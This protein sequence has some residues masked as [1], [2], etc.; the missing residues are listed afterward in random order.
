MAASLIKSISLISLYRKGFSVRHQGCPPAIIVIPVQTPMRSVFI[1]AYF[2]DKV[3]CFK[4][5]SIICHRVKYSRNRSFY[6]MCRS[7]IAPEASLPVLINNIILI[8]KFFDW[9]FNKKTITIFLLLLSRTCFAQYIFTTLQK[10]DGLSSNA[11]YCSYKDSTGFMWFGTQFG[12]NR[13]DGS[14]FKI[15]NR[16]NGK[17]PALA[18]GIVTSVTELGR[19]RIWVGTTKGLFYS[20]KQTGSFKQVP[21]VKKNNT[22]IPEIAVEKLVKDNSNRL[23]IVTRHG[24]FV[25]R[26]GKAMAASAIYNEAAGLDNVYIGGHATQYDPIRNGLWLGILKGL[27]FLDL[28]NGHL[29]NYKN[30][31]ERRQL[32]DSLSVESIAMDKAGDIWISNTKHLLACYHFTTNRFEDVEYINEDTKWK[33]ANGCT[34]LFVDSKNRLWISSWLGKVFVKEPGKKQF[35]VLP[36]ASPIPFNLPLGVFFDIYEDDQQNLWIG[37]AAGVS[38]LEPA[39]FLE[40][41]I[42]LP[43]NIFN[44][45]SSF[46]ELNAIQEAG[47]DSLWAC[48][49]D[50]LYVVDV[51]TGRNKQYIVSASEKKWNR[52]FDVQKISGECWCGTGDGIKILNPRTGQFRPFTFYAKGHE[53]KNRSVTWIHQDRKGMIWFAAWA[54]GV[55]IHD[56]LSRQTKRV[57]D[58]PEKLSGESATVNSLCILEDKEGKIWLSNGEKG[59]RIFNYKDSSFSKPGSSNAKSTVPDELIVTAIC[60]DGQLNKWLA[61][62]TR[63]ILK[64]DNNGNLTDS[65]TAANGLI[66]PYISVLLIDESGR[67]W[68]VNSEGLFYINTATKA[69]V[70]LHADMGPPLH[71]LMGA[72]FSTGNKLYGSMANK[73]A[74]IDILKVEKSVLS[75]SPLISGISVFEKEI[76]FSPNKPALDLRYN[77]NFFSI[78]FSSPNHRNLSS[79]QYAYM[80]K[81]FDKGWVYCNR[82]Q[83]ASYTNVP[84]GRY[85]FLVKC[86]DENGKWMEKETI[87]DIYIK[88]PFWKT[89]W[90]IG[91]VLLLVSAAGWY[92]YKRRLRQQQKKYIDNT[93]DYFANSVYGQNSVDEI[94]WDIARNCISQLRFEDCVVYLLDQQKNRMVQK[95]AYG[96]KNPKGHEII[97]PIEIEIGKGIVGTVAATGRP[98]LV[99]DTTKDKRYILDDEMRYSELAVPILHDNKV[100]GVIDSE[101]AAKNFFTQEHLKALNTVAAISA[102]K[103]AEAT[104][105]AQAKE[106][107]IKVLE[108]N[109]MLAE[110]QLMALRAQ[111]NPHFVFNC[112]NSIQECIV[113]GKYGEAS[114]YLNK[115]S[116]LFRLVL[117]NSGKKLVTIEEEKEVLELYL[118][119]EQM[120]F[121][122]SF[123]YRI[124]IDGELDAEEVLIPSM[125][126]QPYV[127]NALWHGLMHKEGERK[128]LV[129]FRRVNNEVFECIIDDNGIGRKRSFEL[130]AGQSK[131]KR[132]ESKGLAISKDRLDVLQRQGYHATVQLIDKEDGNGNS[133]GTTIIIQLSSDLDN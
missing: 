120:R 15:Y 92:W 125:L 91:A 90:F 17:M 122:K 33:L 72:A 58:L 7:Q 65:I 9:L 35:I 26:E 110:S 46:T 59:I 27:F 74:V 78:E 84:N 79:L 75:T 13:F 36:D 68:A 104:A 54:D 103:I 8:G 81:G 101:N 40:N 86:T 30:N 107:E 102:N 111:M 23:W 118:E 43:E 73:I 66:V 82:R 10:Q 2:S 28:K 11:V 87:V 62:T 130:K 34:G 45:L 37:G 121:E 31:P 22:P 50:G 119:L 94:C 128:L 76:D 115:F 106:N 131:A 80:L 97:N 24:L 29:L 25:Y 56:P 95:A 12:L 48:R 112:L 133:S 19:D 70:K 14:G 96:P 132:H 42:E 117:N 41:I 60:E 129:E 126:V 69:V 99:N 32:F 63:G 123:D 114:K 5:H 52:F 98:L 18:D 4:H 6:G 116:K 108:I 16:E 127:E 124:I 64:L 57:A 113:T 93:I 88:P 39:G 109:K 51:K 47:T 44:P 105:E 61:T 100:I 3:Y 38:K 67:M 71:D 89:A 83:I 49:D 55:Y 20:D 1:T 53:I 21:F 77:Q 85:S